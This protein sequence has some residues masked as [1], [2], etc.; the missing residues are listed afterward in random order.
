MLRLVLTNC[1]GMPMSKLQ[2]FAGKEQT[3]LV[4]SSEV[5]HWV[6]ALL[7]LVLNPSVCVQQGNP[8]PL[9]SGS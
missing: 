4:H 3:A 6:V 8:C 2:N 5:A 9:A 1:T 7:G